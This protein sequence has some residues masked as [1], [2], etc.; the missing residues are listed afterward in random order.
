MYLMHLGLSLPEIQL[1]TVIWYAKTHISMYDDTLSNP[2]TG[3]ADM[4]NAQLNEKPIF[5]CCNTNPK[6]LQIGV[7]SNQ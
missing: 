3:D 2:I 5:H 1:Y 4:P 6:N 7:I